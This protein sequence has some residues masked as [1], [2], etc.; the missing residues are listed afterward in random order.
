M[1]ALLPAAAWLHGEAAPLAATVWG[2]AVVEGDAAPLLLAHGASL[3]KGNLAAYASW[4]LA[5][6]NSN[7]EFISPKIAGGTIFPGKLV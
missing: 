5:S 4:L 1:L 3:H 6:E 2:S 7:Q